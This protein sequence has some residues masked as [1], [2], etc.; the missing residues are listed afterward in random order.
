MDYL[1]AGDVLFEQLLRERQRRNYLQRN[2]HGA[3][4]SDGRRSNVVR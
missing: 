3:V 2:L 4:C 1:R